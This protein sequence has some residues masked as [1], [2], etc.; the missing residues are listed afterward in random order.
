MFCAYFSVLFEN[1]ILDTTK[2]A[3]TDSHTGLINKARWNELMNASVPV[4]ES[5]AIMMLDLN[6]LKQVNDTLGHEA[7]DRMILAFSDIL[8]RALPKNSVICRWG[9]DEFAVMITGMDRES[10]EKCL[11][12]IRQ[13]VDDYNAACDEPS[14]FYAVGCAFALEH[15]GLSRTE[16]LTIA[17]SRMYLDKQTWYSEKQGAV[18]DKVR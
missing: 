3:Y 10:V 18:E 5:T 6:G 16:L 17:D 7:G 9:G 13:E 15:P 14:V 8:R 1:M 2:K 11:D 12:T 4:V